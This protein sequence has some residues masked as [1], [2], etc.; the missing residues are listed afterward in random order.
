[1]FAGRLD[2]HTL[3]SEFLKG[4]PL[5]DSHERQLWVY[6]PP[7]YDDSADRLP[8]IY[9]IQGYTGAIEGW[10]QHA[11]WRPSYPQ[12]VDDLF[13]SGEA[14][15]ALVVFV[16][17]WTAVGG[18]QYLDS[19]GTGRYHSYLCEEVV[20]FVDGR[21]RTL[22]DRDHRAITGK[23]SGGYG[24]MITPLL[25]PDV[26]GA[27][28]TH[29]GDALFEVCYLPEF[30]SVARILR[31]A[32][33]GSWEA[34]LA[35]F[36]SGRP[37]GTKKSDFPLIE[38]Y[39]YASCYSAEPDGT[40]LLPFDELGAPVPDV[41]ERWLALDPV[42]MVA[43]KADAARSLNAV[44]IDAGTSDEYYLDFGAVAY[45]RALAAAGVD[46]GK[47]HFELFDGAHGQIEYRYP[48][49]LKWLAERLQP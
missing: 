26:F 7:G 44:W 21:Y 30:A 41:W 36:R 6:V 31:D 32:Y 12:L 48:L 42:R 22:A 14:P 37:V 43:E 33:E 5:G 19:P 46:D 15:P 38:T 23:S 20:G 10:K 4:N 49:A 2:E 34:F 39:G 18:S 45:Q 29:A 28:A 35:D 11:P 8:V 40:V 16:D 3:T 13:A 1:M 25:R 17:A 47:V 9:V 24:A 27:L